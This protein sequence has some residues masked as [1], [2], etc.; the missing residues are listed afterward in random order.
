MTTIATDGKTM[1][2]DSRATSGDVIVGRRVKK[3]W[4][5][6]D[7]T[8]IGGAGTQTQILKFVEWFQKDDD[9]PPPKKLNDLM[10]LVLYPDG[11]IDQF[12]GGVFLPTEAPAA[13]GTGWISALTAM[14]MKATPAQAVKMAIK[15]DVYSGGPI[16]VL[17]L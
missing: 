11:K 6:E 17:S 2:S 10:V 9:S 16:Q 8:I 14:D 7:G 13:I 1:A 3:L 15:R 4:K 5:L 12:E